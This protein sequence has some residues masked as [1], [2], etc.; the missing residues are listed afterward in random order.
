MRIKKS[1]DVCVLVYLPVLMLAV[2]LVPAN[3][4]TRPPIMGT[5]GMVAVGH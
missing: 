1:L 5:N 4:L 3:P 2:V